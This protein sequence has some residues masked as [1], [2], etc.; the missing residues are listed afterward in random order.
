[1][2]LQALEIVQTAGKE[3]GEPYRTLELRAAQ[4]FA[5]ELSEPTRD[6]N[7][8]LRCYFDRVP[9]IKP[10]PLT[11]RFFDLIPH[12]GE[13][14]FSV[15]IHFN[16]RASVYPL[17]SKT[18]SDQALVPSELGRKSDRWLLVGYHDS[19][20][21]LGQTRQ[22]GLGF[23]VTLPAFDPPSVGA[24][25]AAGSPIG[26]SEAA[27]DARFYAQALEAYE[28]GD[29]TETLRVVNRALDLSR[30][31]SLFLPELLALKLRVLDETE[32]SPE[33][34]I[35]IGRQWVRSY[36][37]HPDLPEMMLLL[38]RALITV[39]RTG[40]AFY[41]A[42][43]L[44]REFPDSP[45]AD[46]AIIYKSDRFMAEGRVGE[47]VQGYEQV[48]FNSDD[49]PAAALAASRLAELAIRQD[50]LARASELYEKILIS[51]PP[52]FLEDKEKS[53]A[54]LMQ[55][56][57]HRLVRPAALLGEVL[58][59][60][61][62][63][64]DEDFETHLRN[65]ARWQALSDMKEKALENYKR[66]LA[67]F[68]FAEDRAV[69][70]KEHDL[71]EFEV[72]VETEKAQL[73]LYDRIITRYPEDEAASRALYQKA[74]LLLQL[75]RYTEVAELLPRLDGLDSE[76]FFDYEQQIRQMERTL[77]SSFIVQ[78]RCQEAI[79]LIEKRELGT[80]LRSDEPLYRCAW[81]SH[82]YDLAE[83]V[84]D[85]QLRQAPPAQ[86]IDWLERR[87]DILSKTGQ[88]S[89]YLDESV[90]YLR[91]QRA[92]RRQ[93][94]ADRYY[95]IARMHHRSRD[96]LG[97]LRPLAETIEKRFSRDARNIDLFSYMIEL[98]RREGDEA[99]LY[100]Y[101]KK[102]VNHQRRLAVDTLTPYAELAFADG[103]VAQGRTTEAIAVLQTLLQQELAASDRVR[104]L[105]RLGE[106]LQDDARP[107]MA[108]AV[109]ERCSALE[110][111]EGDRWIALCREQTA[112]L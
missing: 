31:R 44:I 9:A 15:E 96:A 7:G 103:A 73:A 91:M 33:Q 88:V 112:P 22:R 6:S 84:V 94:S 24:L 53:E 69:M 64:A 90:R 68:E 62:D 63:E 99:L 76:L 58:L 29:M 14:S 21:Y 45:Y 16:R 26:D 49:V 48:L 41:Y 86:T 72:G 1:M 100:D 39:G 17:L 42:D 97:R 47:A 10:H 27:D 66:Y 54:L 82:A 98:A 105:Y 23:P 109:F 56:A 19:P 67:L 28:G 60:N 79:E 80:T 2:P 38:T 18:L 87:L 11:N 20:P 55:M 61:R 25:D 30:E 101:G 34:L 78:E 50:D 35:E 70:T 107:E 59:E 81:Q 5:C 111:E 52:F 74:Q 108:A 8:T 104:V 32:Q 106:I 89:R 83:A 51:H 77:L 71:L 85:Y 57:E 40:D 12:L 75:G 36:T 43:Q 37:T 4:P 13:K 46:L 92:L 3:N 102:L 93:V 65:L 110:A 95:E